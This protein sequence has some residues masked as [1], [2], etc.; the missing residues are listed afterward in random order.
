MKSERP[1]IEK[2]KLAG[3]VPLEDN[4]VN[5]LDNVVAGATV[6]DINGGVGRISEYLS[7]K[8]CVVTLVDPNRLSFSYRRGIVPNSTVKCW[9]IEASSIKLDKPVFDYVVVRGTEYYELAKKIAKKGIVD[10]ITEEFEN[11]VLDSE[12]PTSAPKTNR[13]V[14]PHAKAL[15]D[16]I[17]PVIPETQPNTVGVPS[18]ESVVDME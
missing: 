7:N 2:T 17:L 14:D 11:V 12:T 8:G 4:I 6:L 18:V 10:L 1:E 13:V 3:N 5:V 15:T 9:N 16:N